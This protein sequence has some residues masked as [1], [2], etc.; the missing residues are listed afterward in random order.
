MVA[1][2]VTL[3][4]PVMAA[5]SVSS[6]VT[7]LPSPQPLGTTVTLTA[8]ASDPTPGTISYRFE[9]GAAS[10]TTLSMVRDYSVDPTFVFTPT[11]HETTFQFVVIARN[12]TTHVKGTATIPSFKFTTL[13]LHNAPVITPTANPLVVLF[14]SPPCAAGGVAMRVST[15]RSGTASPSHTSWKN[16][17]AGETVNFI[18]AGMR[19]ATQYELNS[20]TWN[21]TTLTAGPTLTFTTGT[22]SITFPTVTLVTPPTPQDSLTE[23]FMLM[24][25]IQPF[26]LATDLSG[27]PVWY[28]LDPSGKAPTLTRP[29]LGGSLLLLANG[30]NS[31]GTTVSTGQILREI[32]L[33]GN[34]LRETNATRVSEQVASMSGITSNCTLG[35]TDCLVGAFHHEAIQL[36]NGHTLALTDEEK[37]FTDGTQGSSPSNPVDIIGDIIVDLDTNWQLAGYWRAFDHMNANRAA[38]L[39]ETCVNGAGGCP[40]IILTAGTAQDWLHGNALYFTPSD[41]SVLFSMRHQDWVIKIDYG[42]GSGSKN[43]L[44]TLGKD[45]DFTI[46]SSDPYPWFSHQHDAGFVKD[47]TTTLALFDNGNTRVSPPPLGLGSG[48]SRGYVLTVDQVHMTVTPIMLADLGYFSLALGTAELL[49]NGDYHFEA[50]YA[51]TTPVYSEGIEVFPNGTLG[52]TT[53][54]NGVPNYRNFRMVDLYNPPEKD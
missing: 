43:I 10:G 44:W 47:G 11:E 33:A 21:G 48:D 15:V 22:P 4:N 37:I 26:P 1:A 45:G 19:A 30:A 35:G 46:N 5:P 41:G 24:S 27:T 42:N 38:V 34:I 51:S 17:T 31:A 28:Y 32:D 12:N 18:V 2:G 23:R 7:S 25:T 3:T 40:P 6:F 9:I 36:P 52:Y 8:S 49:S 20:Q 50:G 29:L 39:G 14:S 13:V 53:R 16:C 54:I